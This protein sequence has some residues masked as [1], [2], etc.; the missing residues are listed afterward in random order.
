MFPIPGS[1]LAT[2]V[3]HLL[4]GQPWL[5]DKLVPFQGCCVRF[6]VFPFTTQLAVAADG[7]L[8]PSPA[9]EADAVVE[10]SGV[11]ALRLLAGDQ[12]AHRQISVRGDAEMAVALSTVLSELR[13]DVEEDL[14]RVLGDVAAHRLVRGAQDFAAWQ[15]RSARDLADS[16]VEYLIEERELLARPSDVE[17]WVQGVD[18]LRDDVERLAKRLDRLAPKR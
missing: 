6:E 12:S 10:L 2:A 17:R 11:T 9:G 1:L 14:S 8:S 4:R 18:R 13:W 15:R 7:T 5:R 3:A 16:T